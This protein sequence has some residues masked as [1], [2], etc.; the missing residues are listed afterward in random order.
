MREFKKRTASTF[1]AAT[2]V[3]ALGVANAATPDSWI[4]TK[5]K[6]SLYT[7]SG[8]S[9]TA[10][11]VDTVNGVVTLHGKVET[12][13]EK[14][15]AESTVKSIDGVKQVRNLLQVVPSARENAVTATDDQISDR[16]KRALK[17]DDLSG[18]SVQSVNKGVVLLAGKVDT[19]SQHLRAIE[20]AARVPG[21][22]Q[23][24]SEIKSPDKLADAEIYSE[25]P[26]EAA[27]DAP[28]KARRNI[29]DMW[30]TSDVKMRL[31]ADDRTPGLDVN[32]DTMGGKVTLFGTVPSQTA[33][34]AA[35]EDAKKVSGVTTVANELEIV[36]SSQK[37]A[38]KEDDGRIKSRVKDALA[39]QDELRDAN[40]SVEVENGV[41]RLTGTVPSQEQRIRAAVAARTA[42][43]VRAVRDELRVASK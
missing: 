23:V 19:L 30:I 25:P 31:I 27:G 37:D 8:V 3:L 20:D 9:G 35:E 4:T 41:A 15:K 42:A 1:V 36:P 7:T 6:M 21:V 2:F 10:I 11:N 39:Q 5:A 18:V 29:S 22:K 26:A 33:K 43:G 14:S 32:V 28:G 34:T 13:A 12:A 16:V 17:D 24:A 38:V 40:I